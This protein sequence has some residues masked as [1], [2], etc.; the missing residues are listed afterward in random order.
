[1]C[2]GS[3]VVAV[4]HAGSFQPGSCDASPPRACCGS[5][6]HLLAVRSVPALHDPAPGS[7]PRR[8]AALTR[9]RSRTRRPA[10][11][12]LHIHARVRTKGLTGQFPD[13]DTSGL[14]PDLGWSGWSEKSDV[15][16]R[17]HHLHLYCHQ[18]TP[19]PGRARTGSNPRTRGLK[20]RQS[21]S[22]RTGPSR[23]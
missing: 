15:A 23:S 9:V 21:T 1:M 13:R 10:T 3:Q 17:G 11:S 5:R 19:R 8:T 12:F 7:T 14:R 18:T 16:P 6:I 22:A 20:V 4:A 2:N